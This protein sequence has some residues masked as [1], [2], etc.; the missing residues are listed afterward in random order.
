MLVNVL[1]EH[2]KEWKV[3]KITAIVVCF[4][5]S[6]LSVRQAVTAVIFTKYVR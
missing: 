5:N 6:V 1:T 4:G 3:F 2:C